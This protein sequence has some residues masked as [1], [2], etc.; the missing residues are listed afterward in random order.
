MG[1]RKHLHRLPPLTDYR[2][3]R[4]RARVPLDVLAVTAHIPSATLSRFERGEYPLSEAQLARLEKAL[5][6]VEK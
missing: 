2:V 1:K 4:L 6:G 5:A 3:R